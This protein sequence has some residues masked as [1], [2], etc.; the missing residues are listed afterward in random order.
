MDTLTLHSAS[1]LSKYGFNDGD[2]PDALLDELDRRGIA[3]PNS[4]EWHAALTRLVREHLVPALDQ[5]VEVVEIETNH[6]PIRA[7][8]VDGADV[9][10]Q[11]YETDA[12]TTLTPDA[13]SVPIDVVL[14]VMQQERVA[15]KERS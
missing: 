4:G 15:C 3:Y 14:S 10:D 6:N 9:S 2:E 13:V 8:T 11:W 12:T 7:Q 1:L 5:R